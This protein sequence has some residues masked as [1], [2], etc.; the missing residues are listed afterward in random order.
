MI[1]ARLFACG[2]HRGEESAAE[3]FS[4]GAMGCHPG[5]GELTAV[6]ISS[7]GDTDSDTGVVRATIVAA[8][9]EWRSGEKTGF[10]FEAI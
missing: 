2:I 7:H 5:I 1:G 3:Q 10:C 6:R 9:P 4:D 8:S